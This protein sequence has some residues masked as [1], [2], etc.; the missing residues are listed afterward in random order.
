MSQ[1]TVLWPGQEEQ[2]VTDRLNT[3]QEVSRL[4]NLIEYGPTATIWS[5]YCTHHL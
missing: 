4:I 3:K 1:W 2:L 5:Y